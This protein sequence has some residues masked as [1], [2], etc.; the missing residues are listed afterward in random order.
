MTGAATTSRAR[1]QRDG[2][3]ERGEETRARMLDVAEA[4]MAEHGINGV[5]LRRIS[6][7]AGLANTAGFQYYFSGKDALVEAIQQR[8]R[9]RFEGRRK[10]LLAAAPAEGR[11]AVARAMLEVMFAPIAEAMNEQG[12]HVY[13]AFLLQLTG[14]AAQHSGF[15][16]LTQEPGGSIA[17][18]MERLSALVPGIPQDLLTSRV[19]RLNQTFLFALLER[20]NA[21]EAGQAQATDE[22]FFAELYAFMAGG[23]LAATE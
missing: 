21:K 15:S 7:A 13:A 1:Q 18:A 12:R 4:L 2:R 3:A 22:A 5:S 10:Q 6:A 23:L 20:D 11:E 16:A 8:R 19:L 17:Q 14:L 9:T